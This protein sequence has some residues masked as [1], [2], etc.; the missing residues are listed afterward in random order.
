MRDRSPAVGPPVSTTPAPP[1]SRSVR[2]SGGYSDHNLGRP[3]ESGGG[4]GVGFRSARGPV[5]ISLMVTTGLIAIDATILA[6]A[7]PTIVADLGGF[8]SFPWLFSVYLLTQAVSVPI[9]SKV[10]DT[11]GRKPVILLGIGLFGVASV[12]CGLAWSMPALIAFRALQGLGAGAVQPMAIT[13]VGD[14]YTVVERAKVQGYLASVWAVSA[15]VGPTLGGVFAEF[16]SWPWIFFVNVPLCVLAAWLLVR[17]LHEKVE[18]TPHRIDWSGGVLLTVGSALLILGL[19]EGGQAWAWTSPQGLAT[20]GGG[21]ALLAAFVAVERR[22]AEPVLPL[23]VLSRRLLASTALIAVGVGVVLMG[24]TTYVPTYLEAL[25]GVSPLTS[26]LTLAALTLG[27]PLA[28]SNAGRLYLRIGFRSTVLVGVGFVVL[29][30]AALATT[31]TRPSV[32]AVGASCFVI[33]LGMGLVAAPSLIAAQASVGWGERAVVT[34]ANMFA[35]SMG[36][37]VGVAALGAVVNAAMRGASALEDPDR[38]GDAVTTTFAVLVAVALATGLAALA[39]PRTDPQ[40][41]PAA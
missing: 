26:G 40:A 5:L 38:F 12:L 11:I 20:L 30:T 21:A 16:A 39:M 8:T 33:G 19:L 24:L 4:D 23:W 13:I 9:Y 15:V 32:L 22:A 34:G 6:T 35:R 2:G 1:P 36:S 29:G 7:V 3:G 37:A 25:L 18:R 27:W 10:A 14:L 28:A 41:V 17:H 31:S